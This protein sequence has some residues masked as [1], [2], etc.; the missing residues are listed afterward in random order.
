MCRLDYSKMED[1]NV[2]N[3]FCQNVITRFESMSNDNDTYT[4][5]SS[6]ITETAIST[7]PKK[8]KSQPGWFKMFE[9]KLLP[10]IKKRNTAMENMYRRWTRAPTS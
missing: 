6:C 2:R 9:N 1:P 7:L 4:N 8:G 10:L 5:L 3:T